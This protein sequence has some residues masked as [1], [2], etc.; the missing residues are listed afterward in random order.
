[1]VSQLGCNPVIARLP[2]HGMTHSTWVIMLLYAALKR[3]LAT[4]ET[5]S[6]KVIRIW[7]DLI[8][9]NRSQF[10]AVRIWSQPGAARIVGIWTHQI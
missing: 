1:M 2:P 5:V 6:I 8:A 10:I 4:P 9:I 7:S 3:Y